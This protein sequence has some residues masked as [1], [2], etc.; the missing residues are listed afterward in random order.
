MS[1][2]YE[3]LETNLEHA[4][5]ADI[6]NGLSVEKKNSFYRGIAQLFQVI[7]KIRHNSIKNPS[8]KLVL[9]F[10]W[11]GAGPIFW[12]LDEYYQQENGEKLA[13]F[14]ELL[15]PAIGTAND[16]DT[17]KDSG[18]IQ[19]GEKYVHM[20][21]LFATLLDEKPKGL[22]LQNVLKN[23]VIIDEVQKGGT[24]TQLK[25]VILTLKEEH[26]FDLPIS[27]IAIQDETVQPQTKK[28]PDYLN[29]LDGSYDKS[30]T[31]QAIPMTLLVDKSPILPV[32][33]SLPPEEEERRLNLSF[34]TK[35]SAAEK[36]ESLPNPQ[37]ENEF[38]SLIQK[39]YTESH[40]NS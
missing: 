6:L 22:G 17:G 20:R 23:V 15:F 8:E 16:M 35:M 5:S 31:T 30:Y 34:R 26:R 1:L 25:D 14:S 28:K 24:L 2:S 12:A 13:D 40:D 3:N 33:I 37:A 9:I 7:E 11:R 18:G 27:F 10:P 39:M 29:M 38:R 36:R 21:E 4:K 32:I 19:S